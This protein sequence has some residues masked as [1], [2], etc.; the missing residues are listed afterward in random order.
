M[1]S[2]F[3]FAIVFSVVYAEPI[4]YRQPVRASARQTDNGLAFEA[5]LGGQT[6]TESAARNDDDEQL[7][8]ENAPYKSAGWRPSGQLLVLPF[9]LRARQ[10]LESTSTVESSTFDD[11]QAT[12]ENPTTEAAK[13]ELK[14][15]ETSEP[16]KSGAFKRPPPPLKVSG[17]LKVQSAESNE[18]T[19]TTTEANDDMETTTVVLG[20]LE[21]TSEPDSEAVDVEKSKD[22]ESS[23]KQADPNQQQ[24]PNAF[25]PAFFVQLPDG[26]YQRIVYL[27]A[28]AVQSA[29]AAFVQQ[30][31]G[32]N[33]QFQQLVQPQVTPFGFNPITN[34]K[35]VTFSSQYQAF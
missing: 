13:G 1:K 2:I 26:T 16:K 3:I 25:Q 8:T 7:T 29:Q 4:R 23:T 27:P 11:E 35:I 14:E 30:P 24:V 28:P 33:F 22:D 32:A 19:S 20:E 10:N 18:D 15:F 21:T 31:T 34:P 9:E 17:A 6:S 12:T 5:E